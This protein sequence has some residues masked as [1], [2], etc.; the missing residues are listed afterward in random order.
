MVDSKQPKHTTETRE[1][2]IDMKGNGR[3][4]KKIFSLIMKISLTGLL[5]LGIVGIF[6]TIQMRNEI[7]QGNRKLGEE[8]TNESRQSF[9]LEIKNEMISLC[10]S[11][12]LLADGKLA[13]IQNQTEQVADMASYIYTYP[14]R[15]QNVPT[16]IDYLHEDQVGK[17]T[18]LIQTTEGVTKESIQDELNQDAN[19]SEI[20][21]RVNKQDLNINASYIGTETGFQ[22]SADKDPQIPMNK[23]FQLK[24]RPWYKNAVAA[25]G[26]VWSD[27][28]I[29]QNG[30]GISITC[31]KP[32]YDL[33]DGKKVLKGVASSGA[34]LDSIKK[35][36]SDA[37][38]GETGYSYI[39]DQHSNVV[40]TPKE[41]E[42]RDGEI[43][44]QNLL[45]SE[46]P[47]MREIAQDIQKG[48]SGFREFVIDGKD[49]YVAYTSLDTMPWGLVTVIEKAEVLAPSTELAH[50]IQ[51]TTD[52][53]ILA[54]D[55]SISVMIGIYI[56]IIILAIVGIAI[57]S[58]RFSTTIT[59]P[60]QRLTEHAYAISEGNLDE[61]IE[62]IET[63]DEIETLQQSFS[64]MTQDLKNQIASIA[65]I[66][67]E[68]ERIA[69]ELNVATKIQADMLP[70]IFP[71]F[72]SRHEFDIYASMNPAKEVGGDFYDFFLT[73]EDHLVL[74]MADVSGKGVP[75]ALFMVIAKTL[76]KNAAQLTHSPKEILEKVNNQLCEN[77]NADMFVT[78]WMGIYQIST[79]RMVMANAGH[80]YPALY[81]NGEEFVLYKDKHGMVLA[82][83]ENLRYT[84]Y[85]FQLNPGDKLYL[86]T[87]GVPEG[88][89]AELAMYGTERMVAALNKKKDEG[90]EEILKYVKEDLDEFVA[91]APQFDDVTM[92][93]LKINEV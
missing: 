37:G 83:M 90:P 4:R 13:M 10:D 8:A 85:E 21:S 54:M 6:T 43:V 69:T 40:I 2:G 39:V 71:P 47:D 14:E 49:M 48:N 20:L 61:L 15:F 93:C 67:A 57:A 22:L 86:Y 11:I 84:E 1:T 62:E 77:N 29:D 76:L 7:E 80:E 73:D 50:T 51:N 64:K 32:F 3:L 38:V 44:Y 65:K 91:E 12:A 72:P 82:G 74:V 26:L 17:F 34:T 45:Q 78:V 81:R 87:D 24:E 31:S 5:I 25:D 92:M 18:L 28:F 63:G 36:I 52:E 33:S 53:S 30:H 58:M 88:T 46:Q 75:A 70:S 55:A 9:E 68:K 56:L 42:I 41:M 35:I 59:K 16:D 23:S 60:I 19:L 27:V 79:G 89:N 66:S